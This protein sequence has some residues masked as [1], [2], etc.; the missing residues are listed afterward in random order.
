MV[1]KS[2]VFI[3]FPKA[4]WL[5]DNTKPEHQ[6][7]TGFTQWLSPSY[8]PETNPQRWYHESI[9]LS[10]LPEPHA[11]P[12]L[13]F[14]I[15]GDQAIA[16]SKT[17]GA[18]SSQKEKEDHIAKAFKPYFSRL[19][20]FVE[21][22]KECIPV[23]CLATNWLADEFAGWG[24]YTTFRTGL[25][26]A[27]TDIEIMREGLPGRGL[28][29]AGEH[30]GPFIAM[31]T[32]TSAYWS[33]ESVGKRIAAVYGKILSKKS[34]EQSASDDDSALKIDGSITKKEINVRGFADMPLEKQ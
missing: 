30:T 32:A 34:S 21:G 7:F 19:P 12:T 5:E 20:H 27:D 29:F 25:T 24:S 13:L 4:F 18:L 17:L 16:L 28:W 33:G 11:H 3:S 2:Q 15:F 22:D 1:I 6:P 26:E 14:Y 8:A 23:S 10:T 31:G 9:D